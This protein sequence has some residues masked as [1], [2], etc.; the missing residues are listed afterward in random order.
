MVTGALSLLMIKNYLKELSE[1]KKSTAS[2][3]SIPIS[4]SNT[5]SVN[6]MGGLSTGDNVMGSSFSS[7]CYSSF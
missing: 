5:P 2:T 3:S 4:I 7:S 6:N 1:S